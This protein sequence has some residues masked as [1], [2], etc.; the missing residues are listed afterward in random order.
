MKILLTIILLGIATTTA[1][2][3]DGFPASVKIPQGVTVKSIQSADYDHA[4]FLIAGHDVAKEGKFAT[5]WLDLNY[6]EKRPT[7]AVTWKAWEPGLLQAGWNVVG[8][9][10]AGIH[11]LARKEGKNDA[12]LTVELG[13]FADPKLTFL[14]TGTQPRKFDFSPPGP[15]VESVR[16]DQDW[17]Y[18]PALPGAKLQA[19]IHDAN[20][21]IY[22]TLPTTKE[23]TMV[24]EHTMRKEY[25]PP[26]RLSR[27]E[28]VLSV[29]SALRKAGWDVISS[30]DP[31][32]IDSAINAHYHQNGREIWANIDGGDEAG[33]TLVYVVADLGAENWSKDLEQ[34][35]RLTL[36]GVTFDFNQA[37]LRPESAP[38][39]EKAAATLQS[40]PKLAVEVQ[41]HT[42]NVGSEDYNQKLSNQR[43]QSVLAWLTGHGVSASRLTSKGY[44]KSQP[45]AA[46]DTDEGRARN[47]RV[48]LT[49]RK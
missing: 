5:A 37:T 30:T 42:D 29:G 45:I 11:T 6:G 19:T 13:D 32:H 24:S 35:C 27:F 49:C 47:R 2:A 31:Q 36:V 17:P 43:A 25:S 10:E 40:L 18:L 26:K 33:T 12:F 16:D 21:P 3:L 23:Y 44:G 34:K 41:G 48:D 4:Q 15:K 9:N 38:V 8:Q 22:V 28:L 46:N 39:L 7:A 14:E 1:N 20:Q